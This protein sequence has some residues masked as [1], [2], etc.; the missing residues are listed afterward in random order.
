MDNNT[1]I[2]L[3]DTIQTSDEIGT[4][5]MHFLS[6]EERDYVSSNSI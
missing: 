1:T 5:G 2:Y 6:Q 3:E 4:N